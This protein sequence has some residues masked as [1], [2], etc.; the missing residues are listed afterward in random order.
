MGLR[1]ELV[2]VDERDLEVRESLQAL[3]VEV[4]RLVAVQE[5]GERRG[6]ELGVPSLEQVRTI[7]VPYE[8]HRRSS[9]TACAARPSPRPV[10]PSRSVVVAR[11]EI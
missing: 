5:L 6:R 3:P 4:P 9:A 7:G 10:K 2:A 8:L 1:E 11:T